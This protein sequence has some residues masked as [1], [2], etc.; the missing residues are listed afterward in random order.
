MG[1]SKSDV[2]VRDVTTDGSVPAACR[3]PRFKPSAWVNE[4]VI[5]STW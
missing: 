3:R 5:S 4:G 1:A 2:S